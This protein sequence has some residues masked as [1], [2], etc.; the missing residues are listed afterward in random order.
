M[1][2]ETEWNDVYDCV[3]LLELQNPRTSTAE[4]LIKRDHAKS[5]KIRV[6]I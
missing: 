2:F 3:T 5:H 4:R 1:T 6:L